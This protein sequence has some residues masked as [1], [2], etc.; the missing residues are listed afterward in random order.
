[1]LQGIFMQ[2]TLLNFN[3][4][5][6]N[7]LH[8]ICT[9]LGAIFKAPKINVNSINKRVFNKRVLFFPLLPLVWSTV[10][11]SQEL[12]I[13]VEIF[14]LNE[15]GTETINNLL[16][17]CNNPDASSGLLNICTAA[18]DLN[19]GTDPDQIAALQTLLNTVAPEEAFSMND[20]IVLTGDFQTTNIRA[21]LETLRGFNA[22]ESTRTTAAF[23]DLSRHYRLRSEQPV[24]H[25]P[26]TKAL[27]P[28]SGGSAS[29]IASNLSLFT[30]FQT[31]Q[32]S[33][34]GDILQQDTEFNS[35]SFT[36]GSDYRVNNSVIVGAGL[37]AISDSTEFKDVDGETNFSGFNVTLFGTWYD[38]DIAYADLVLDFGNNDYELERGIGLEEGNRIL[39]VGKTSSS[40]TSLALSAGRN[41]NIS[42]WELGGYL[43]VALTNAT[44]DGYTE[45]ATKV[46]PGSAAT[47]TLGQQSIN[48]LRMT[49]GAEAS[50]ILSTSYAVV[51]P[52]IR[53][54]FESE[55]EQKKDVVSATLN[56]TGTS[57][58][59][60][61]SERDGSYL[62]FGIGASAVFRNGKSAF[63][64][65]E[66][67][68]QHEFVTQH[69]LKFGFRLEF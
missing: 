39:A 25:I 57:F 20:A 28:D 17:A 52:S 3:L 53:L 18:Q 46:G 19:I 54:E 29:S 68:L 4:R 23:S 10:S 63:A 49:I 1:M 32:G 24:Q 66:S 14:G 11:Y 13:N 35:N 42:S 2:R 58:N 48:S 33:V 7:T 31:S 56:E 22:S 44:I 67:H 16:D 59:Y 43:R 37:G 47:F 41:F 6:C 50:R 55:Q 15:N 61:G 34:D 65:F 36:V 69:R 12:E 27:N 60:T 21:R 9:L 51:I 8:T 38:S 30:S 45:S 5:P 64:F 26:V 62:N 40:V